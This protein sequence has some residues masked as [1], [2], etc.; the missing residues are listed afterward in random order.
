MS[1]VIVRSVFRGTVTSMVVSGMVVIVTFV[2]LFRLS[3]LG[4]VE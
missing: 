4:G 2:R 1:G 3:E